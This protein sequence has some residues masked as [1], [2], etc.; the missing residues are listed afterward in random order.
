MVMNLMSQCV[1]SLWRRA[2]VVVVA[3]TLGGIVAACEHEGYDYNP[4]PGQGAIVVDNFTGDRIQVFVD[5]SRL[6]TVRSGG[7]R[8]Y[9]LNPGA[10]RVALDSEDHYRSWADD[11]DVLKDR[12]TILE[13][14]GQT[15]NY[16]QLDVRKYFD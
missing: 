10:Y 2:A 16:R 1:L 3:A 6:E 4:P 5:G 12:L 7:R 11:V 8:A 9:D 15:G 13:V 14:R